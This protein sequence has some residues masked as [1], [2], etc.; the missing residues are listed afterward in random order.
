MKKFLLPLMISLLFLSQF[1]YAQS[2]AQKK[3]KYDSKLYVREFGDSYDPTI[4]G[5]ASFFVPGLGQMI[6]GETGRGVAFLGGSVFG[7]I[8]YFSGATQFINTGG[9]SGGGLLLL[10]LGTMVAVDIWSIVDAVEVAKVNNLY[11]RDYRK[12]N[13]SI[14]ISP[15][16]DK[17]KYNGNDEANVGLALSIKF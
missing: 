3:L 15:K 9:S 10:G 17:F 4:A 12:N 1:S 7:G 6:S 5:V 11:L 16:I 14:N 8:L 2:Y 13:M